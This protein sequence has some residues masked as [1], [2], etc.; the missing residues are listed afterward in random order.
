ML[1]KFI[2][3]MVFSF[4]SFIAQDEM[5][6]LRII[7]KPTLLESE[8]ISNDVRD[9]NREIC[10]GLKIVTDLKG[11]SYS[12]NNGIVKIDK[13]PGRD[14]LFL[15]PDERVVEI[16]CLGYKP[17]KVILFEEGIYLKS[18]QVWLLEVTGEKKLDFIPV[19]IIVEPIDANLYIDGKIGTGGPT[20][21]LSPG[22]HLIKIIADNYQSVEKEIFVSPKSTLFNFILEELEQVAVTIK[23]IPSDADIIIDGFKKGITDKVLFLFPGIY[24]VEIQKSGHEKVGKEIVI[25]QKGDNK[26]LFNLNKISGNIIFDITPSN[27]KLLINRE[28]Y[29]G[30]KNIALPAGKHKIEISADG[31]QTIEDIID[32]KEGEVI[33]RNYILNVFTGKLQ[34]SVQP[35]EATTV[36]KK[37]G[38]EIMRW[39]G[40]KIM[41]DL[42]SG[43]YI[44]ETSYPGYYTKVTNIIIDKKKPSLIEVLLI[45]ETKN[46]LK[47]V[48]NKN[49]SKE[50][51]VFVKGGWFNMGDAWNDGRKDE[52]PV[53]RVWVD[54]FFI[55]RYEVTYEE[56]IDFLNTIGVNSN[57]FFEGKKYI[58]LDPNVCA[59]SYN[60]L[61]FFFEANKYADDPRCPVANVTWDGAIAFS[62]WKGGRLP[63]EAEWEY[64]ARGG[65]NS[66]SYKYSG[67]DNIDKV[68]WYEANSGNMSHPVGL[69]IP[70]ELDIFDMSGN[71]EE[72]CNDSY[73]SGY[74]KVSPNRN[75]KG[76]RFGKRVKRGGAWI[77][78]AFC[79]K[80]STR[81]YARN[82]FA[83]FEV[84]FRF[85][86]D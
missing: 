83:S 28:N 9:I 8:F 49:K 79:S 40:Y 1:R 63:T 54:D 17:L 3:L 33:N 46:S 82:E 7:G 55:S 26:F 52:I 13:Q 30:S 15:S 37:D 14:V 67:S 85:V 66:K 76:A 51:M 12:S 20:Y 11:F 44:A 23:S 81:A 5:N 19:N 45:E 73:S 53:H 65:M 71:V 42:P 41:N 80:V 4:T 50:M 43:N 35:L 64:A 69:L 2:C 22:D 57:G 6:E 75:P 36:L 34:F 59:V 68:A 74:Y 29:S 24:M 84:G 56:Y 31:Y 58:N 18:T 60:G 32:V 38:K 25:H 21:Q 77:R 86:K 78:N 62:N 27:A 16:Y 39:K 47:V 72:W 10:A 48:Q 70:N 61:H